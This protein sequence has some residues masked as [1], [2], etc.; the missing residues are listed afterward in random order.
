MEETRKHLQFL[1]INEEASSNNINYDPLHFSHSSL[2]ETSRPHPPTTTTKPPLLE[3]LTQLPVYTPPAS[4]PPPPPPPLPPNPIRNT[5]GL[6]RSRNN[7]EEMGATIQPP[8]PWATDRRAKIDSLESLL[9]KGIRTITGE[10]Q[11]KKCEHRCTLEFDLE[12]K[13]RYIGS[14]IRTK[15]E[16]F[17]ERA[18]AEWMNPTLPTCPSCNQPS[19][20]KP[21]IPSDKTSINWLF[22]L[23]GQ[24]LGCCTLEQLKFFCQH[25][26]IHRTGAKNRLLYYTYLALCKQL[27]H[28]GPFDR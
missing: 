25:N 27:D 13:F 4:M 3:L 16:T 11:C 19:C 17:R 12:S 24:M 1:F 28:K 15:K 2:S 10:V 5:T 14:L 21:I 9:S 6:S 7:T 18:P 26:L 23:L 8:F 22:L 20:L